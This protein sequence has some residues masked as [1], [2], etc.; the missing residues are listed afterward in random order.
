MGLGF[1]L[2]YSIY[3]KFIMMMVNSVT[4]LKPTELYTSK[5]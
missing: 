3:S 2:Q 1:V 4:T 5:G